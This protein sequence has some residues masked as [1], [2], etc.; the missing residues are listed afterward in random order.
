MSKQ[1]HLRALPGTQIDAQRRERA[2]QLAF[3]NVTSPLPCRPEP[4]HRFDNAARKLDDP[5]RSRPWADFAEPLRD[6]AL[7]AV[8]IGGPTARETEERIVEAVIALL[9]YC[10][11]PFQTDEPGLVSYLAVAREVPEA[12][13][14]LAR[15]RMTPTPEIISR[16]R[17][18]SAEA[19]GALRLH[20]G[21]LS[22]PRTMRPT[23]G[24]PNDAA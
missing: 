1:N 22:R 10:T 14:W 3:V 23:V 11:A 5:S 8:R 17:E 21:G 18:E 13:D 9:D 15:A 2:M 4:R 24:A 20:M 7:A 6:A 12:I 19:C 16:A